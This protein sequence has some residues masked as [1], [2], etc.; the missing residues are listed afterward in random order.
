[1]TRQKGRSGWRPAATSASLWA[2]SAKLPPTWSGHRLPA[3]LRLPRDRTVEGPIDLA[4]PGPVAEVLEAAA[5]AAGKSVTGQVDEL[6]RRHVEE[7]SR[8]P[9]E[10]RASLLT[11]WPV[12]IRPSSDSSSAARASTMR[13]L[14]PSTTGQPQGVRQHGE[15]Q[16]EGAGQRC[17]EREHRVGG[18]TGDDRPG[19]DRAEV[20]G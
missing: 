6:T 3:E 9:G 4:D 5:V 8:V 11:H 12:T 14:P 19:L 16:P 17:V 18:G 10:G 1:M 2:T 15:E 20:G 7:R 13:A